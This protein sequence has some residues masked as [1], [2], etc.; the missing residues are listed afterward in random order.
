[1][2]KKDAPN[3]LPSPT[4]KPRPKKPS[5]AAGKKKKKAELA[6]ARIADAARRA[7]LPPDQ[8]AE[9]LVTAYRKLGPPPIDQV[10]HALIYATNHLTTALHEVAT[11][12]HIDAATRWRVMAEI[13]RAIGQTHSKTLVQASFEELKAKIDSI[14]GPRDGEAHVPQPMPA[15]EIIPEFRD[16]EHFRSLDLRPGDCVMLDGEVL[17]VRGDG[18][19]YDPDGCG[20]YPP[21]GNLDLD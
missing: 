21:D 16:W 12:P 9:A 20:P 1:M 5:G 2:N 10:L 19:P 3:G 13:G 8:G 4:V 7:G 17:T 15:Q 14:R 11:D 6:A 18:L